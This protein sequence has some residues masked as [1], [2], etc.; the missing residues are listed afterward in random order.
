MSRWGN[1]ESAG[2]PPLQETVQYTAVHEKLYTASSGLEIVAMRKLKMPDEG[3]LDFFPIGLIH[4]LTMTAWRELREI[5]GD[6]QHRRA[7]KG[8]EC[9]SGVLAFSVID[10][11][12]IHELMGTK[13]DT[14]VLDSTPLMRLH[15]VLDKHRTPFDIR[16][17]AITPNGLLAVADID[18]VLL[19]SED[20]PHFEASTEMNATFHYVARRHTPRTLLTNN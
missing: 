20:D 11:S 16:I 4:T 13:V 6:S 2:L 19:V 15:S 1:E 8:N 12:M 9:I 17:S 7:R 5:R 10:S 14:E 18:D 3:E